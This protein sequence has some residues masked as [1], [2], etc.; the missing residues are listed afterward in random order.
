MTLLHQTEPGF[1]WN[2]GISLTK[3]PFGVRSCD[4]AI[5]WP[6]WIVVLFFSEFSPF[7]FTLLGWWTQVSLGEFG[8]EIYHQGHVVSFTQARTISAMW[9]EKILKCISDIKYPHMASYFNAAAIWIIFSKQRTTSQIR[10][11]YTKLLSEKPCDICDRYP[12]R[13][14]EYLDGLYWIIK[15]CPQTS[16]LQSL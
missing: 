7:C 15:G 14:Q 2:K 4:V 13:S 8:M 5:I 9:A 3:P 1:P 16:S 10:I 11:G 6:N 12:K